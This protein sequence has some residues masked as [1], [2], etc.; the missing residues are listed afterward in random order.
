MRRKHNI[1]RLRFERLEHRAMLAGTVTAISFGPPGPY[2]VL[3]ITGDDASNYIVVH[4]VRTSYGVVFVQVQGIGTKIIGGESFEDF[5]PRSTGT[6]FT[7]FAVDINID[8]RG[9]NDRLIIYNTTIP[10]TLT[11]NMG[12]G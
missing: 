11:I 7:L 5:N 12:S 8:L 3:E 4:E 9:G 2:P 10:G 1:R 6:S